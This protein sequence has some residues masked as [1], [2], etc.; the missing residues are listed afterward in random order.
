MYEITFKLKPNGIN[1]R[2]RFVET[3][4]G[5][6]SKKNKDN[7][8]VVY[9]RFGI[10]GEIKAKLE[11]DKIYTEDDFTKIESIKDYLNLKTIWKI[12]KTKDMKLESVD[13][14]LTKRIKKLKS[15]GFIIKRGRR[16]CIEVMD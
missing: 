10:L 3:L 4:F 11:N 5:K 13:G 12:N 1:T 8:K 2:K 6:I 16:L 7:K 15:N 9:Y 14:T